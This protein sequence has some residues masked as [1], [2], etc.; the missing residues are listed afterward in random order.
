MTITIE[1]LKARIEREKQQMIQKAETSYQQTL[2]VAQTLFSVAKEFFGYIEEPKALIELKYQH[3]LLFEQRLFEGKFQVK[4]NGGSTLLLPVGLAVVAYDNLEDLAFDFGNALIDN[5]ALF[6]ESAEKTIFSWSSKKFLENDKISSEELCTTLYNGG[7][8]I[9]MVSSYSITLG[10]PARVV[11]GDAHPPFTLAYTG[12]GTLTVNEHKGYVKLSIGENDISCIFSF[13]HF[14]NDRE[15]IYSGK[16]IN[17]QT[18]RICIGLKGTIQSQQS[19][20]DDQTI[21]TITFEREGNDYGRGN[22]TAMGG[23]TARGHKNFGLDFCNS[24]DNLSIPL[25]ELEQTAEANGIN[26][27]ALSHFSDFSVPNYPIWSRTCIRQTPIGQLLLSDSLKDLQIPTDTK[28]SGFTTTAEILEDL[29]QQGYRL[30]PTFDAPAQMTA[31]GTENHTAD[32]PIEFAPVEGNEAMQHLA[33]MEILKSRRANREAADG[34]TIPLYS[35]SPDDVPTVPQL[36][37][38]AFR[39]TYDCQPVSLQIATVRPE[40]AEYVKRSE[41]SSEED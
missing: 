12:T 20:T 27:E 33:T 11:F 13:N 25:S 29:Q 35:G 6:K 22:L 21:T 15:N 28:P 31:D 9:P 19:I 38:A 7:A 4:L 26:F 39:G 14:N 23:S 36:L 8:D 2:G 37:A 1:L 5:E 32:L 10:Q 24:P 18:N 17:V 41:A 16:W 40:G 3:P 30:D 34:S